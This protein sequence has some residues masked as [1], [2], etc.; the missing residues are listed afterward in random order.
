MI[1]QL[2]A[3]NIERENK[4][5]SSDYILLVEILIDNPPPSSHNFHSFKT[6]IL[7]FLILKGK[8]LLNKNGQWQ[9]SNNDD[10]FLDQREAVVKKYIKKHYI[11]K[12]VNYKFISLRYIQNN[13]FRLIIV[14]VQRHLIHIGFLFSYTIFLNFF[15]LSCLLHFT[16]FSFHHI[17]FQNGY[18]WWQVIKIFVQILS[19]K[20]RTFL[21]K[22]K[23]W[24]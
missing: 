8:F 18:W 1:W 5:A 21:K 4:L 10:D 9:T 24:H 14:F 17:S 22:W 20:N 23:T 16:I 2:R 11:C 12:R 19:Y 7:L 6:K 15:R 3:R 13:F